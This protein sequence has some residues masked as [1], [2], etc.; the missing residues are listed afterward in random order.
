VAH[1]INEGVWRPEFHGA[2]HYDPELRQQAVGD[3]PILLAAAERGVLPFPGVTSA[4]ELGPWREGSELAAELDRSLQVFRNLFGRLP[5][6][7]IAPDYVWDGRCE[8][9]WQSRGL[10][11]IQAKREQRHPR[12]RSGRLHDRLQKVLARTWARLAHPE[13]VYLERNC[14]FEP[15]QGRSA[16]ASA[17]KCWREIQRAWQRGEPAVVETHR[18]NFVHADHKVAANG[19]VA[20]THLLELLQTGRPTPVYLSD[21]ELAQLY[22]TGT[23]WSLRGAQLVLRNLTGSRRVIA[24]PDITGDHQLPPPQVAGRQAPGLVVLEPHSIKVLRLD[25]PAFKRGQPGAS[26]SYPGY[27]D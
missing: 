6:S 7:I 2:F 8:G 9:L 11:I 17:E 21:V 16:V 25:D 4:W 23:S 5:A 14:R 18:I 10:T 26:G 24:I 19:L 1:A 15:V 13:R 12:R 22:R 27:S 3:D 20:L